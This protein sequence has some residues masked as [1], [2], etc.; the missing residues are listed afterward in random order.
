MIFKRIFMKKYISEL[1]RK[2]KSQ[3]FFGFM[4]VSFERQRGYAAW[5]TPILLAGLYQNDLKIYITKFFS[6][7]WYVI[8][9]IWFVFVVFDMF[10]FLPGEQLF[11]S[12][13][14]KI[15]MDLHD[16]RKK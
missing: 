15:I 1:N 9:P 14:N 10:V 11:Y 5:L 6:N 2:E 7:Y 13:S 3:M 12:K 8:I 16:S 4:R